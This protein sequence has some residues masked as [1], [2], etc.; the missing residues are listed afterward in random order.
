NTTTNDSAGVTLLSFGPC[1]GV[2]ASVESP[3]TAQRGVSDCLAQG[4]LNIN[5][6]S[7]PASKGVP[8]SIFFNKYAETCASST[9]KRMRYDREAD[10]E[11]QEEAS[12]FEM[13]RSPAARHQRTKVTARTTRTPTSTRKAPVNGIYKAITDEGFT[14]PIFLY[15]LFE[16]HEPSA[17]R[18]ASQFYSSHAPRDLIKIWKQK[19]QKRPKFDASFVESAVDVVVDRTRRDLRRSRKGVIGQVDPPLERPAY[20]FPYNT[21][22]QANIEHVIDRGFLDSYVDHAKHLTRFLE[23]VLNKD[24]NKNKGKGKRLSKDKDQNRKKDHNEHRDKGNGKDVAEDEESEEGEDAEE[25]EV[26]KDKDA[27]EE[28]DGEMMDFVDM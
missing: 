20:Q 10:V 24:K 21:V 7:T 1:L 4:S 8:I 16:S 27:E 5:G 6:A 26:E 22:T 11:E 17:V 28:E 2:T 13:T 23:G 14:L 9:P 12:M 19:L 25:Q 15:A 3:T 18:L